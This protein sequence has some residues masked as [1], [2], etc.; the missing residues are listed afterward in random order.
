MFESFLK[1]YYGIDLF[2]YDKEQARKSKY[3]VGRH[4]YTHIN[5]SFL[6]V[7]IYE[8]FDGVSLTYSF[9]KGKSAF[10]ELL[11]KN[12]NIFNINYIF[13]GS[14]GVVFGWDN[15]RVFDKNML[16]A[17]N[18]NIDCKDSLIESGFCESIGIIV[19]VSLA[20]REIA[21]ILKHV[22]L[23]LINEKISENPFMSYSPKS[24]SQI[25]CDMRNN[26]NLGT[27]YLRV[28]FLELIVLFS[29]YIYKK[30]L[31]QDLSIVSKVRDYIFSHYNQEISLNQICSIFSVSKSKIQKDFSNAYGQ[32]VYQYVKSERIPPSY[33]SI[34]SKCYY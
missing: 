7:K 15:L 28:K 18:L 9:I 21:N 32:S 19:D 5:Q 30:Y 25:F 31:P 23:A 34:V 20:S 33:S 16:V 12:H 4:Y 17:V 8:L 24:I 10:T 29:E 1:K 13:S 26:L 6:D 2:L 27:E 3:L 11:Y 14:Y 22:D